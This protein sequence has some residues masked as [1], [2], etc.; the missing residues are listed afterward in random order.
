MN[1]VARPRPEV[2]VE[3]NK[4]C[5]VL[6]EK[7]DRHPYDIDN[8]LAAGL[9]EQVPGRSVYRLTQTGEALR[10]ARQE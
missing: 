2:L 10:A 6:G 1:I 4:F 9:V 8:L 7:S 3:F 5:A